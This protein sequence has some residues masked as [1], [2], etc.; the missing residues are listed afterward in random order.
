MD[1]KYIAMTQGRCPGLWSYYEFFSTLDEDGD[2]GEKGE[3][4]VFGKKDEAIDH[5]YK[6]FIPALY[7]NGNPISEYPLNKFSETEKGKDSD[8]FYDGRDGRSWMLDTE[9]LHIVYCCAIHQDNDFGVGIHW[10]NDIELSLPV[11]ARTE[12]PN[13]SATLQ[14]LADLKAVEGALRDGMRFG[15][16][17]ICVRSDSVRIVDRLNTEIDEYF[18]FGEGNHAGRYSS[19][20]YYRKNEANYWNE[21]IK[22]V[23]QLMCINIQ[24]VEKTDKNYHRARKLA[25]EGRSM[26]RLFNQP[27]RTVSNKRTAK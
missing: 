4:K 25:H 10:G 6:H 26:V 17:R 19:S 13:S 2:E 9:G 12:P 20:S 8:S 14:D 15:K 22:L 18:Q 5:L 27:Q 7:M 11:P 24:L 3:W 1:G 23:N 21:I 16:N